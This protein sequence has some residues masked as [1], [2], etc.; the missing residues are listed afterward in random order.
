MCLKLQ[1]SLD[2]CF[3]FLSQENGW[4][5]FC[6]ETILIVGYYSLLFLSSTECLQAWSSMT[7]YDSSVSWRENESN[8]LEQEVYFKRGEIDFSAVF[9][10]VGAWSGF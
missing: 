9:L 7:N 2:V 8:Y 10:Q 6:C 1:K 3:G 4:E 5:S